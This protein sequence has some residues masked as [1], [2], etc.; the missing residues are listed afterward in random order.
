MVECISVPV[1]VMGI[2][3]GEVAEWKVRQRDLNAHRYLCRWVLGT[4]N[5]FRLATISNALMVGELR[6]PRTDDRST[7]YS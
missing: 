4:N 2:D 7:R 3:D 5:Q 1:L 6:Y